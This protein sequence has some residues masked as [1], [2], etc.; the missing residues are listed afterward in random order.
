MGVRKEKEIY[1]FL[2]RLGLFSRESDF[3]TDFSS[4]SFGFS[5]FWFSWALGRF[6]SLV[7]LFIG[8]RKRKD[9]NYFLIR[10]GLFSKESVF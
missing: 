2:I 6:I 4:F 9:I 3:A 10:L 1:Y 8:D 7:G 5:H